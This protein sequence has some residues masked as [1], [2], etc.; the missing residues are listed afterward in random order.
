M[1]ISRSN[2]FISRTHRRN[3]IFLK[4]N[5][6]QIVLWLPE[7]QDLFIYC[8]QTNENLHLNLEVEREYGI[9]Q[10]RISSKRWNPGLN[11]LGV[12]E[13]IVIIGIE[14]I[15]IFDL[16]RI[17]FYEYSCGF[18]LFI[19]IFFLLL[20]MFITSMTKKNLKTMSFKSIYLKCKKKYRVLRNM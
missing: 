8:L 14:Y 7:L 15:N 9:S 5:S 20:S 4:S 6:R 1:R 17:L 12:R 11:I 3:S 18:Y 19:S 13:G 10:R 16:T 2:K